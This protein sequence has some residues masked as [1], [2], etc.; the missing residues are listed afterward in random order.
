M[1]RAL[2]TLSVALVATLVPASSSQ[3]SGTPGCATHA[4]YKQLRKGMTHARVAHIL[5]TSGKRESYAQ[6]G[7]YA[8]EI[9][10]YKACS[11]FSVVTIGFDKNPGGVLKLSNKTA[12]WVS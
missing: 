1:K 5:G 7:G 2:L 12:V 11:Q 4:E 6:S 3:A 8:F 10:S 9:R